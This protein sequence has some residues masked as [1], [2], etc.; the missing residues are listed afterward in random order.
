[1]FLSITA[2]AQDSTANLPTTTGVSGMLNV[3]TATTLPE[4]VVS[5]GYAR[6]TEPE[7]SDRL[8]H[9]GRRFVGIGL[10]D[11]F[12]ISGQ[13]STAQQL[14]TSRAGMRDLSF[15]A[16][17]HAP[18]PASWPQFAIGADDFGG[19]EAFFRS[20]YAVGSYDLGPLTLSGGYGFGEDRLN[21]AFGGLRLHLPWGFSG[22]IEYDADNPQ[23]GLRWVSPAWHGLQLHGGAMYTD[24]DDASE[25]STTFGVLVNLNLPESR[26]LD[27][28]PLATPESQ[29]RIVKADVPKEDQTSAEAIDEARIERRLIAQRLYAALRAIGFSRAS[30]R[31]SGR[32]E[33][34]AD[35]ENS[36]FRVNE[37]DAL[38]VALGLMAREAGCTTTRLTV[39]LRR[40]GLPLGSFRTRS[41]DYRMFLGDEACSRSIPR[42]SKYWPVVS[43]A[44]YR[45]PAK[46]KASADDI[47]VEGGSRPIDLA[48]YPRLNYFLGTEVASFAYSASLAADMRLPLWHGAAANVVALTP[49]VEN[50]QFESGRVFDRYGLKGGLETAMLYQTLNSPAGFPGLVMAG[51]GRLSRIFDG[52]IAEWRWNPDHGSETFSLRAAHVYDS[53]RKR[54]RSYAS[55][56]YDLLLPRWRAGLKLGYGYFLY[57]DHGSFAEVYRDFGDVRISLFGQHTTQDFIGLRLRLPLSPRRSPSVGP[58]TARGDGG[59]TNQ[60]RTSV[61]IDD[62]NPLFPNLAREPRGDYGLEKTFANG[63]RWTDDYIR[64]QLPRLREAYATWV[65]DDAN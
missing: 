43:V 64:M 4:G 11:H 51:V 28:K 1:M 21:G 30:V 38:G 16:K 10:F 61:N 7:L 9:L 23:G 31:W 47:V 37:L 57:E 14:N 58:F 48:L 63:G 56:T 65:A 62:G 24:R 32:D 26:G 27:L 13:Y 12:E 5:I 50:E 40:D 35:V 46:T 22:S 44:L 54:T 34:L 15:G 6:Y 59:W 53:E 39:V 55:G 8:W 3:P 2:N 42:E 52:G 29:T 36:A 18:L 20:R 33:L 49:P 25:W 19:S 60:L 41:V 45:G 17:L